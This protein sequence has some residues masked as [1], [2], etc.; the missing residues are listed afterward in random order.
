MFPD[1]STIRDVLR[2]PRPATDTSLPLAVEL[3]RT[4]TAILESGGPDATFEPLLERLRDH[5]KSLAVGIDP[6]RVQEV[7]S[8]LAITCA[9]AAAAVERQQKG[10]QH[11][12]AAL[13]ATI[14]QS[15]ESLD[16]HH[17]TARTAVDA[18]LERLEHMSQFGQVGSLKRHVLAEAAALR[19]LIASHDRE[20]RDV[21]TGLTQR[22]NLVEE[23]LRLSADEALTDPL[24]RVS[25]RQGFDLALAKRIEG[26]DHATPLVLALFDVDSL[27]SMNESHGQVAGDAVLRHV[28]ATIRQVVRPHDVV[29][30][31]GGDEFAVIASGLTLTRAPGRLRQIIEAIG[32]GSIAP[33]AEPVAVSCGAAEFSA[34]DTTPTLLH[35]SDLALREAKT[36]GRGNVVTR[37]APSIRSLLH[38]TKYRQP[39]WA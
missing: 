7:A 18:S 23:Q 38:P 25:N 21:I 22:L 36:L 9:S 39:N 12:S 30:R 17:A 31:I 33:G 11:D 8:A 19:Q 13:V 35:R 2:R 29:A 1:V 6:E 5:Q 4:L 20:H 24:T 14:R 32:D 34:G 3:L 37:A 27:R 10:R 16:T 28:A 26:L 15:T